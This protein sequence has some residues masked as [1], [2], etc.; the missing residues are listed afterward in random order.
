MRLSGAY[1]SMIVLGG[2]AE[3]PLS[4]TIFGGLK[5]AYFMF[6]GKCFNMLAIM[7]VSFHATDGGLRD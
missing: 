3:G 6:E 2:L 5:S 1:E 7:S 4:V